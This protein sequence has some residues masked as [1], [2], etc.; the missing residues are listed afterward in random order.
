MG[1]LNKDILNNTKDNLFNEN[2]KSLDS[3]WVKQFNSLSE[4]DKL[5]L[6]E[7][8]NNIQAQY[9]KDSMK[10]LKKPISLHTIGSFVYK[11]SRKDFYDLKDNNPNMKLDEIIDTVKTRYYDRYTKK[12]NIKRFKKNR[13][14]S[15]DIT[16]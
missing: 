1:L 12:K 15:L 4:T 5:S 6:V 8:F 11:A 7:D 16:K 13:V 9:I 2:S 14:I 10:A 3:D